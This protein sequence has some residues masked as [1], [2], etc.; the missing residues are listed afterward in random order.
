[1]SFAHFYDIEDENIFV[2]PF[3]QPYSSYMLTA[4]RA[5]DPAYLNGIRAMLGLDS[6]SISNTGGATA[7][8][9]V[10]VDAPAVTFSEEETAIRKAILGHNHNSK[11]PTGILSC[12]SFVNLETVSATPAAESGVHRVTFY[13]WALYEEFMPSGVRLTAI[14]SSHIPVALTFDYD[15]FGYSLVDYWEPRDGSYYEPDIR[16]KVPESIAEDMMDSQKFILIQQQECY[17]Q[18]LEY[19]GLGA[20]AVEYLLETI[21]SSPAQS[22]NPGDYIDAHPIE[23]RELLYYGRYTLQYCFSRFEQGGETGLEGHIMMRAC[24]EIAVGWGEEPLT[25]NL[26]ADAPLTGQQ[27]YDAFKHRALDL[28]EQYAEIGLAEQYPASYLLLSMLGKV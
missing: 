13:G 14:S 7:P 22:S 25:F 4:E 3:Q 5:K 19:T 18:A 27:W 21:C 10:D 12:C 11:D 15:E 28:K 23:Y 26:P 24:E 20:E 1:M 8:D 6:I 2:I 9:T 16:A 17:A